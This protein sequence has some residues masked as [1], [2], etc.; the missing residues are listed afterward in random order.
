[1]R[2]WL[3][4]LPLAALSVSTDAIAQEQPEPARLEAA[5]A[6][7]Q[8]RLPKC[9]E[10]VSKEF[11]EKKEADGEVFF[12]PCNDG[13]TILFSGLSCSVGDTGGCEA[14]KNSQSSDGRWWRSP[15]K[16]RLAIPD[17]GSET[18]F[19][20][21][22]AAGVWAYIAENKDKDAFKSWTKWID[23][24]KKTFDF[25]PRYCQDSRCTFKL[26]DCPMLD[27]LAVVL[28]TSNQLCDTVPGIGG[29]SGPNPSDVVRETRTALNNIENALRTLPGIG[30][31]LSLVP[32]QLA[33]AALNDLENAAK[34]VEER[35]S[36][37]RVLARVATDTTGIVGRLNAVVNDPG[38]SRHNIAVDAY[39]LQKYTAIP[40][41]LTLDAA[42]KVAAVEP[43]NAFLHFVANGPSSEMLELI[44]KKCRTKEDTTPHP[45]F[46]W[47]W[48]RT[49]KDQSNPAA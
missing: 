7:W 42:K 12:E 23:D 32:V 29:V 28:G 41:P 18:T 31:V 46:Q 30:D 35:A 14:V 36:H 5:K 13:D 44:Y 48:E 22:H 43:E 24:N 45:R 49:D 15:R 33:N 21:D 34:K 26:L 11:S 47:I 40:S 9:E 4:S 16:L 37:I 17:G 1:M 8:A 10:F 39:L 38:F 6:F 2:I 25:I 20:N 3:L 19:S 27:R